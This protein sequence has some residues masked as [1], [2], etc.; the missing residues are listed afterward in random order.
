MLMRPRST[1][2]LLIGTTALWLSTALA[3]PS[4]TAP[5]APSEQGESIKAR[6]PSKTV[7]Y[8]LYK[9]LQRIG[10]ERDT[11][12]PTIDG[13]TEVKAIFTF[14]D[15]GSAV[16]LSALYWLQADGGLRRYQAFGNTARGLTIDDRVVQRSD[17]S[18]S[19]YQQGA[20]ET[21]V[22][23]QK[24]LAAIS[25]YAPLLSQQQ[26]LTAWL[27]HGRPATV[28]LLPSGTARISSRGKE[29][30]PLEGKTVTLEHLAVLGLVWGREDAWLDDAGGLVAVITRDAE[31]DHFE[32]VREGFGPLLPE[33]AKRA[34]ADAV[35][36]LAEVSRG[37]DRSPPGAVALVGGRLID[38]NGGPPI[39]DAVVV[40]QGDRILAAG[41]RQ[42]TPIPR[43]A[44]VLD[45]RG[46]TLLP[47][48]W[49]MHAHVEQVEQGAVYLAAGVTTVRDLGN[50][51]EFITAVRDTI[52]SGKGLGPRVLTSCLVD[53]DG[54]MSLGTLIIH[55]EA[56]IEPMLDKLKTA[57]CREVKVYSSMRP[58]LV[59]PLATAAHRRGMRVTG[60][61]PEDMDLLAALDAGFDGVNH[62]PYV[63]DMALPRAEREKL[64]P[65]EVRRR[66]AALDLHSPIMQKVFDKLA[67]KRPL[68]DDTI[69]LFELFRHTPE[70][71]R[72][73][74][75]GIDKL[76]RELRPMFADMGADK[77]DAAEHKAV[78]DKLLAVLSELHRR[79]VPL[80]AGTDISVP[81]HS[82]HRELELYVQAGLTPMEA[83]QAATVVP[84]RAMGLG[85]EL[86]TL[87]AGKRADLIVVAGNP[88]ADIRDIR[89]IAQVVA[90]GR[91]YDPAT[92]WRLVGFQP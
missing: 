72:R 12:L 32:A 80:V 10:Y 41:S 77:A 83:L 5:A 22:V 65:A 62:L 21:R 36:W 68:M 4:Q 11:Y 59:A 7:R 78:F 26:L 16:P 66:M 60:H 71:N 31:F 25:G 20:G 57:S 8:A 19:V 44:T 50:I 58:E 13:G 27:Q 87:E 89:K 2:F 86:G 34:G 52:A 76:P 90:R 3:A 18:F 29:T 28:A 43:G 9:F 81:G 92:L 47:G 33:L 15:R 14:Q 56:D 63:T 24:P 48:L 51:L 55:R 39:E 23:A 67:A 6:E 70:E 37:A 82:L 75:P 53:G 54:K 85:G 40:Y 61:I 79:G 64:S 91:L 74:E 17:G 49:D 35:A 1:S 88:L 45:V 38:G 46:K 42:R 73:T 84:A 69:V 30:Y